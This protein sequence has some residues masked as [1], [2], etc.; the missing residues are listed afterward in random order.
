MAEE[1]LKFIWD[2]MYKLV[3]VDPYGLGSQAIRRE[4]HMSVTNWW[5]LM[6]RDAF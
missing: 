1:H 5:L 4:E 2:W 6:S 3:N